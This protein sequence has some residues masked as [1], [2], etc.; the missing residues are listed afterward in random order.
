MIQIKWLARGGQGG[1][2]ASR[3]LGLAAVKKSGGYAQA[4]PTFGPERRGAPVYGFTRI[5]DKPIRDH[6]QIYSCDYAVVLDETLLDAIDIT[7]GMAAGGTLF[8]NTALDYSGRKIAKGVKWVTYNASL[9]AMRILG[10]NIANTAMMAVLAAHTGLTDPD[11]MEAAVRESLPKNQIDPNIK[12]IREVYEKVRGGY[13]EAETAAN[14]SS[15]EKAAAGDFKV[16]DKPVMAAGF[17]YPATE[18]ELPLGPSCQA[19]IFLEGNAGW[20]TRIPVVDHQKCI[21]CMICWT[22]CPDGVIDRNIHID[23]NFCKGCGLCAH[24]C[25]RKA[26]VMTEEAK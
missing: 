23:L 11:A 14:A 16:K 8:I 5:D 13:T 26:I 21:K 1:F 10:R 19:G 15:G 18:K 20:R 2:T 6:S 25:P 3:L 22:L 9:D 7:A 24:E 17:R 4:F 12:I